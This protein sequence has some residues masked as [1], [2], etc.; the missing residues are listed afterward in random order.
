MAAGKTIDLVL[1]DAEASAQ[2]SAL[3]RIVLRDVRRAL[4]LYRDEE[5]A[6]L[7]RARNQ[8]AWNG[9]ITAV[10]GFTLLVLAVASQAPT[11]AV[12]GG[13]AYYLVGAAIGLFNQLRVDSGVGEG[14]EDFGFSRARL[15]LRR[16]SP[17]SPRSAVC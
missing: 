1:Y 3:G 12:T 2:E 16:C 10:A 6:N 13:V 17:A 11:E 8:L 4:N 9:T 15:F 5:R 14:Q 7:V